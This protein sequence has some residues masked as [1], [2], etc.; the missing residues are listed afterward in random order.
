MKDSSSDMFYGYLEMHLGTFCH[1]SPF[2]SCRGTPLQGNNV[3]VT[4]SI[5]LLPQ[6]W[7]SRRRP[8]QT[9]RKK[10]TMRQSQLRIRWIE[11]NQPSLYKASEKSMESQAIDTD[12]MKS[13]L[14]RL[15]IYIYYSR[16]F[17]L[18]LVS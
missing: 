5:Y 17:S 8:L 10:S 16:L 6:R 9:S 3:E 11:F 18:P 7:L 12:P 14:T 4:S 13:I 15:L 2:Q 1:P